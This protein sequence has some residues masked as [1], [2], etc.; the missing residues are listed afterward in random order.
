MR[1]FQNRNCALGSVLILAGAFLSLQ[2]AQAQPLLNPTVLAP[3]SQQDLP[4]G[5]MTLEPQRDRPS[6]AGPGNGQA[7]TPHSHQS[8]HTGV[9]AHR[10]HHH[11][12]HFGDERH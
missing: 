5:S 1:K 7:A 8:W 6:E 10:G 11:Y 2:G 9:P 3:S 12:K 4:H